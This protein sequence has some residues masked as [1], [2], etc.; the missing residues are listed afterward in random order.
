MVKKS[1]NIKSTNEI[2]MILDTNICTCLFPKDHKILDDIEPGSSKNIKTVISKEMKIKKIFI[3]NIIKT[4]LERILCRKE[5]KII[6]KNIIR[7]YKIQILEDNKKYL[8]DIAKLCTKAY[9]NTKH[10]R[11][12]IKKIYNNTSKMNRKIK[13]AKENHE[14]L[15]KEWK[16]PNVVLDDKIKKAKKRYNALTKLMEQTKNPEIA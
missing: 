8:N 2:M 10:T 6:L 11:P 1:I 13:K 14:L 9:E 7:D 12:T 15:T 5:D 3:T 4:E 16:K